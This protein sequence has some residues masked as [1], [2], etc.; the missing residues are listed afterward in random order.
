MPSKIKKT[1]NVLSKDFLNTKQKTIQC[2]QC[3]NHLCLE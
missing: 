2:S 1:Q 3:L